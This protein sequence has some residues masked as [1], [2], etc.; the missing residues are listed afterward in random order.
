VNVQLVSTETGAHLWA[1][2]ADVD[3][4]AGDPGRD[5]IIP[6]I[7]TEL[8][9]QLIVIEGAR[10]ARERSGNPDATDVMLQAVALQNLTGNSQQVPTVIAFYERAVQL[11]PSLTVALA[12]LA[13]ALLDNLTGPEDPT[14]HATFGRA[15]Q[16]VMQ[17]E[18]LEPRNSFVMI[19]RGY[20]LR[21]EGREPEAITVLQNVTDSYPNVALGYHMLSSSLL[22]AGRAADAIWNEQR[23]I[24]FD[25]RYPWSWARYRLMGWASL[26]LGRYDE[27]VA[28]AQRSLAAL[29]GGGANFRA[30]RY[31]E[32]AAAQ[33]LAGRTDE[34]R[35]AAAE[36]SRLWPT[37]TVRGWWMSPIANPVFAAQIARQEEGMRLAGIRDHADADAN[38]GVVSD[39]ALQMNFS[40]DFGLAGSKGAMQRRARG[41]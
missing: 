15:E 39:D 6:R 23:S 38:F 31:A 17:A 20:L 9:R 4:A 34:A 14:A 11:D 33:A 2:Q 29:P 25:P 28:W 32:I 16:L 1:Y 7:V 41:R 18:S 12:G 10:G 21:W 13:V 37:M 3:A 19:A 26:F 35:A 24:Q 40:F 22:R 36:A 8:W 27:A 30:S 5:E